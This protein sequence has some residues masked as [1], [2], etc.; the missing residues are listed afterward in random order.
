MKEN[1]N[2]FVSNYAYHNVKSLLKIDEGEL[3]FPTHE[4]ISV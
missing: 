4:E 2:D 3:S 1:E